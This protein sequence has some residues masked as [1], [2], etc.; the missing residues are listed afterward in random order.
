MKRR[1]FL[2]CLAALPFWPCSKKKVDMPCDCGV[3]ESFEVTFSGAPPGECN[4]TTI[5]WISVKDRLPELTE[6]WPPEYVTKEPICR[7]SRCVL[8][9][10]LSGHFRLACL[11][12]LDWD[13]YHG[14]SVS[15]CPHYVT[16]EWDDRQAWIGSMNRDKIWRVTHWAELPLT[17]AQLKGESQ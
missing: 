11:S 6:P 10:F 5:K 14:R 2:A 8:V 16:A 3:P 9:S 12:G 17:P 13:P 7:E 15:S 4:V 1:G